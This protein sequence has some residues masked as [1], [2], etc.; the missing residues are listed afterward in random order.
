M[1]TDHDDTTATAEQAT[2]D[3]DADTMPEDTDRAGESRLLTET[4]ERK[5]RYAFVAGLA[6]LAL[7]ALLRFYFAASATI[8]TWIAREYRSLLQAL[9]NLAI[10][11]LSGA[12]ILWQARKLR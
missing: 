9:F 4:V 12:G 1:S 5:L 8:D 7:I 2:T 10:L 3:A 6:L 11:L